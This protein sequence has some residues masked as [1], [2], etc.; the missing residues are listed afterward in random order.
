MPVFFSQFVFKKMLLETIFI[1]VGHCYLSLSIFF[2]LEFQLHSE[3]NVTLID[4]FAKEENVNSF[5]GTKDVVFSSII[6]TAQVSII[7]HAV[8]IFLIE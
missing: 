5:N 1:M 7:A 2:E 8:L 6:T 4:V 3:T